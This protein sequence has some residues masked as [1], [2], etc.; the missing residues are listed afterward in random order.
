M[1]GT[2]PVSEALALLSNEALMRG[3]GSTVEDASGT[4]RTSA[5]YQDLLASI[6]RHGV[7]T[8]IHIRTSRHG[9][10]LV[11]GHHRVTAARDAGLGSVLWTDDPALADRIEA[12]PWQL[13]PGTITLDAVEAF[14]RSACAGLAVALHDATGWPIVEVGHCDGLPLH[15]MVRRPNGQLVDIRGAH[16]DADICDEWEF[17]TDDGIV[18]LTEASRDD[19]LTCYLIDCGEPVPMDLA[20]TFA[21]TV[22]D[23]LNDEGHHS[24][25]ELVACH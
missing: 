8:P 20:R 1:L 9:R 4:K 18:T 23:A 17:D 21:P 2:I 24:G 14:T 12:M 22:L 19:V 5:H 13:I 25:W 10:F 15:F 11:E 7:T 6:R 16:T 3:L